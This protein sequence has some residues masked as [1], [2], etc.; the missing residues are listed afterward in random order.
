MTGCSRGWPLTHDF[1][2]GDDAP[3]HRGHVQKLGGDAAQALGA[4]GDADPAHFGRAAADVDQ[5]AVGDL[6]IEQVLAARQRQ[7]RFLGRRDDLEAEAG[8]LLHRG[9][10]V[11]PV[12]GAAAGFGGDVAGAAHLVALDL[13]RA[14]AQRMQGALDRL[15]AQ[16]PAQRHSLA[17]P[18]RPGIGV[19]DFVAVD[20]RPGHQEPAVVGAEID[21][22]ESVRETTAVP[23]SLVPPCVGRRIPRPFGTLSLG[24]W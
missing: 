10:E 4:M 1:G 22:S 23:A 18:D 3:R 16:R 11:V 9:Q 13:G 20:R 19:D 15:A 5:Q 8:A 24:R 12:A 14:D 6:G 17:Q 2:E 7:P 21:G